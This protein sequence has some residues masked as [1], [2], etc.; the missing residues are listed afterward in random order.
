MAILKIKLSPIKFYEM[1]L[2]ED[3]FIFWN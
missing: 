3:Y 2:F 1:S